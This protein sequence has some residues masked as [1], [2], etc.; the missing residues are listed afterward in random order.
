[1]Y[2]SFFELKSNPFQLTPDP[3]FL[4]TSKVHKKAL[5]YLNYG[6]NSDSTGFIL[7]TGE[8]GTGKTIVIRSLIKEI[9]KDVNLALITNTLVTPD[10][11]ISMINEDFGLSTINK[12]KIHILRDLTD[13]LIE[14]YG[15]GRKSILI[16]DEAQN[17]SPEC[18]EAVRLLSNLETEKSKLLQIVLVGQ[19]ELRKV[20]SKP[21]LRALRQRIAVSCHIFPLMREETGR[22]IFYRLEVAGNR[23]A[24]TF[25]D[26]TIDLIHNFTRGTPRLINIICD[27]LLVSAFTDNTR[28]ISVDIVKEVIKDLEKENRYWQDYIFEESL[29]TT[30]FLNEGA[31]RHEAETYQR[32]VNHSEKTEIFKRI[33]EAEKMVNSA[34]DQLKSE[35]HNNNNKN[36][37]VVFKDVQREIN[38]LK[39]I[40]SQLQNR[41][42]DPQVKNEKKNIW[43]RI[44]HHKK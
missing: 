38:E 24:V 35:L 1:M 19:P 23:K 37:D 44:F 21:E 13:F 8:V 36:N 39:K 33:S 31:V 42:W 28:E 4:F 22:Y 11:L 25:Q 16:I 18:L 17:L 41:I 32:N 34:I 6:I 29:N 5:T 43:A 30:T 26:G 2:N 10:Q 9:K 3:E 27:F 14:Q 12:D 20:L 7:I 15:K 40:T